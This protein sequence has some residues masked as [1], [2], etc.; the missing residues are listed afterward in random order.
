MTGWSKEGNREDY[1]EIGKWEEFRERQT[2]EGI[3]C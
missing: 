2:R 3:V 1:V